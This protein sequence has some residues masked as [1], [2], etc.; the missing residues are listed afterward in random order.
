MTTHWSEHICDERWSPY[1]HP[2]TGPSGSRQQLMDPAFVQAPA[3]PA[4]FPQP[5]ATAFAQTYATGGFPQHQH[6]FIGGHSNLQVHNGPADFPHTLGS[7]GDVLDGSHPFIPGVNNAN[8]DRQ[9]RREQRRP[10]H[11]EDDPYPA[12]SLRESITWSQIRAALDFNSHHYSPGSHHCFA[13]PLPP[14][15]ARDCRDSSNYTGHCSSSHGR[16]CNPCSSSLSCRAHEP[17]PLTPVACGNHTLCDDCR[18]ANTQHAVLSPAQTRSESQEVQKD[19]LVPQKTQDGQ[20]LVEKRDK[21]GLGR[22]LAGCFCTLF[23]FYQPHYDLSVINHVSCRQKHKIRS[24]EIFQKRS[25][26]VHGRINAPGA[27]AAVG[28]NQWVAEGF[29]EFHGDQRYLF[30]AIRCIFNDRN[31]HCIPVF[32]HW[33]RFFSS[34][35]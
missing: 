1:A 7:N 32:R 14:C 11:W 2:P 30:Q 29:S 35:Q 26:T 6:H 24:T 15:C 21:G 20:P 13:H 31:C 22:W 16:R 8:D 17:H 5:H 12:S 34:Q 27:T 19:R 25:A 4:N 23:F 3:L 33:S 28:P 10:P 18:R 9:H